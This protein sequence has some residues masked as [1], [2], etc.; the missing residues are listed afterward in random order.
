VINGMIHSQYELDQIIKW[1]LRE[2][3]VNKEVGRVD[4]VDKF[5]RR[6]EELAEFE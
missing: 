2:I 1:L 6:S 3:K 5:A 4:I